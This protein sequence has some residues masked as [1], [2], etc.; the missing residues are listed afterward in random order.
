MIVSCDTNHR[1]DIV[2]L[3]GTFIATIILNG[4]NEF[5]H[6]FILCAVDKWVEDTLS[7]WTPSAIYNIYI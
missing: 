6:H 7:D 4:V 3:E 5:F 1:Y 2:W